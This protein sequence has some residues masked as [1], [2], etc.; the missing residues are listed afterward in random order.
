MARTRRELSRGDSMFSGKKIVL[1]DERHPLSF[2]IM[3]VS[4]AALL[5][6]ALC[7]FLS[8][9]QRKPSVFQGLI[10]V[11]SLRKDNFI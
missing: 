11:Q 5:G 1:L 9:L 6:K 3:L 2:L 7:A 10:L 4:S 8:S